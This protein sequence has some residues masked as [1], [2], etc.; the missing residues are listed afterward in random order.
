MIQSF[1]FP[2][3]RL[4]KGLGN[5]GQR[6]RTLDHTVWTRGGKGDQESTRKARGEA[7]VSEDSLFS[8]VGKRVLLSG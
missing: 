2:S 4:V 8:P 5:G 7:K 1:C 3:K 6:V